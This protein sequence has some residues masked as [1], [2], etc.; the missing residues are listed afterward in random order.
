MI[1]VVRCVLKGGLPRVL[2]EKF[3]LNSIFQS[4]L[5]GYRRYT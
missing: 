4:K 3:V 2:V 5:R 1:S